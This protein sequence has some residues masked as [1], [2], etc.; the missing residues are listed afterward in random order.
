VKNPNAVILFARAPEVVRSGGTDPFAA[1]PWED[2]DAV[3][4][5]C[6]AD[7]LQVVTSLPETDVLLYRNP[8]FPPEKLPAPAGD[9]TRR[10]EMTPGEF[11]DS[12]RQAVDGAFI[13]GYHRVIIVLENNPLLG[14]D[15][16]HKAADQLG[17]EDDCA[18]FTPA[19]DGDLVLLALKA[20]HP[21]LFQPAALPG[22]GRHSGGGVLA[23]LC[24]LEVQLFPTRLSFSLGTTAN[25]ERLREEIAGLDP[26]GPDF[27]RRTSTVF[28]TIEK[29]YKWKRPTR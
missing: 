1:L 19:G 25:I 3:S 24:G 21:S 11:E 2:L 9:G 6:A 13:E 17:V 12:V 29:K 18:V 5:A 23:G 10:F 4:H 27:P 8:A 14:R 28:R 22:Q 20:N 26:S 15:I 16:F 7:L